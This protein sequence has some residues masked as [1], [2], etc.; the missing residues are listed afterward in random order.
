MIQARNLALKP[1]RGFKLGSQSLLLNAHKLLS[2]PTGQRWKFWLFAPLALIPLVLLLEH[3]VDL[4]VSAMFYDAARGGF[5]W[6][7]HWLTQDVIHRFGLYPGA[8]IALGLFALLIR[9]KWRLRSGINASQASFALLAILTS[10]AIVNLIKRASLT[11]CSWDLQHFGGSYPE[12]AWFANLPAGLAA[13]HC[14]PAAF[15]LGGFSLIGLYFLM[16]ELNKPTAATRVL[17]GVL[18][19]GS[20][21]GTS[22]VARGAH[23]LSHQFWT[24]LICWYVSLIVYFG[25]R[26][27]LRT[28]TL[29]A[30]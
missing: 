4:H 18:C 23:A 25:Y 28:S 3:H 20:L 2:F 6:K 30:S 9:P 14:W 29:H 17:I 27:W 24:A 16:H 13:G 7:S 10:S 11:A 1:G 19:Y 8:L 5:Y 21:L 12:S 26:C 15:S 22:Q